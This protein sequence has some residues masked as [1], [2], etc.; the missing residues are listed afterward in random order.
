MTT[1]VYGYDVEPTADSL[2]VMREWAPRSDVMSAVLVN[3]AWQF[4]RLVIN[5]SIIKLVL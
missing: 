4:C 1:S 5:K 2:H 3:C